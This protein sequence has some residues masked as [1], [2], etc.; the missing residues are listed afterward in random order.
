MEIK[1][2]LAPDDGPSSAL[3]KFMEAPF[4][5]WGYIGILLGYIGN[6]RY[7]A[8][9]FGMFWKFWWDVEKKKGWIIGGQDSMIWDVLMVFFSFLCHCYGFMGWLWNIFW[10][11]FE[12][13]GRI[14]SGK[15]TVCY[16]KSPFSMG[17]STISMGIFNSK[18]LVITRG[19]FVR[20]GLMSWMKP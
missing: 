19:Y 12:T 8:M 17:K 13:Y 11:T 16:W 4:V 1:S 14:P 18:L 7:W 20:H 10:D 2:R 6:Y 15:L 5:R 3:L 9:I